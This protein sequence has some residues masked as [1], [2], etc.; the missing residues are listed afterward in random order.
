MWLFMRWGPICGLFSARSS[1]MCC[2]YAPGTQPSDL[3]FLLP[4]DAFYMFL[5]VGIIIAGLTGILLGLPV[6]R[7]RGDYLA[8][9]T[10]ALVK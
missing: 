9:V 7:L 10:L 5:V 8:I 1:F 2:T 6:L 4:G 3:P